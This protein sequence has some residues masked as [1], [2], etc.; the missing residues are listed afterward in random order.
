MRKIC[1]DSLN[2][3]N[4]TYSFQ[5][6]IYSLGI[7]LFELYHPFFTAMERIESISR[8]R[9]GDWKTDEVSQDI[10]GLVRSM[11]SEDPAV[12]PDAETLVKSFFSPDAKQRRQLEAEVKWLRKR[13]EQKEQD[14]RQKDKEI[15]R[16]K[17][18]GKFFSE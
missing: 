8:L 10:S 3:R 11:T 9:D 4:C 12:R 15:R 5:S 1:V 16:L 14:I 2:E 18:G 7:I 17:S 13:L 6:D